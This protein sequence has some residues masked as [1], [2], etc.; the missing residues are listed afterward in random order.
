MLKTLYETLVGAT[1]GFAVVALALGVSIFIP[2][3]SSELDYSWGTGTGIMHEAHVA[4]RKI[5]ETPRTV[6]V[7]LL[8][9]QE[10]IDSLRERVRELEKE[11]RKLRKAVRRKHDAESTRNN[12][13][14][15]ERSAP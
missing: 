12:A 2:C 7:V 3:Q 13:G 9:M 8:A 10:E 4:K 14:A 5:D 6:S 1:V 15:A 11:Q